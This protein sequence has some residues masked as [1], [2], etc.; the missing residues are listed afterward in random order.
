MPSTVLHC[1]TSRPYSR[2]MYTQLHLIT[3]PTC[4]AHKSQWLGPNESKLLI[5]YRKCPHSC[6]QI[7]Y[8]MKCIRCP[9]HE[10]YNLCIHTQIFS[11]H[12]CCSTS[13]IYRNCMIVIFKSSILS[14]ND[15]CGNPL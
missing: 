4:N 9:G 13:G 14:A 5:G 3:Q 2:S 15:L 7:V 11:V 1:T 8:N 6:L 10:A 12:L